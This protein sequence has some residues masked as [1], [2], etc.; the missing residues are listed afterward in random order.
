MTRF[1]VYVPLSITVVYMEDLGWKFERFLF[2]ADG[3]LNV[4][5]CPLQVFN[6]GSL[7]QCT[8]HDFNST[9]PDS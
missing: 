4:S 6:F 7:L 8:Q 3:S 2:M 5:F 1:K 9:Y